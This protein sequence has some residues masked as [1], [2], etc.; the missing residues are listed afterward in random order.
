MAPRAENRLDPK[1]AYLFHYYVNF[2]AQLL[3]P[4]HDQRNPWS[5]Y[6]AIALYHSS[7]GQNHLL[8]AIMSHAAIVLGNTGGEGAKMSALG[9]KYYITAIRDLRNGIEHDTID[10]VGF[11]ATAM[12]FLFIEVGL[13]M[14]TFSEG[15]Y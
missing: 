3:M 4:V 9:A 6:P 2:V 11:L 10:Y 1:D 13:F 5:R 7:N 12:T 15:R 14:L 8:H